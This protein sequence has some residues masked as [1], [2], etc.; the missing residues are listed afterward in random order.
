MC[1]LYYKELETAPL[2]KIKFI[3][4]LFKKLLSI[5]QYLTALFVGIIHAQLDVSKYAHATSYKNK[6]F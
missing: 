2:I 1:V 4:Y 3:L 5:E 6:P